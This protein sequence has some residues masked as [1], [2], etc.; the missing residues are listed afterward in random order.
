ME[1]LP[2]GASSSLGRQ[3]DN[4]GSR[5]E[6]S[7]RELVELAP[8]LRDVVPP[9]LDNGVE[10]REDK[11]ELSPGRPSLGDELLGPALI[12]PHHVLLHTRRGLKGDLEGTL[13]QGLGELV[14]GLRGEEEPEVLVLLEGVHLLLERGEPGDGKV[15]VLE[16]EPVARASAV[17]QEGH[18]N[19]GLALAHSYLSCHVKQGRTKGQVMSGQV[20][21]DKESNQA[22]SSSVAQDSPREIDR[23]R[24]SH[25]RTR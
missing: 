18:G 5:P 24:Q 21:D 11:E 15:D 2:L 19:L 22:I 13:E 8:A 16:A 20:K 23:G 25:W 12:G 3:L 9:L 17:S 4:V 6:I 10:P 7:S 1:K 14:V